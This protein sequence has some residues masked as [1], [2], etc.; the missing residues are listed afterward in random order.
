MARPISISV[1]AEKTQHK[2]HEKD[3]DGKGALW[4]VE[5]KTPNHPNLSGHIRL[6]GKYYFLNGWMNDEPSSDTSIDS[7]TIPF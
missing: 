7:D 4:K 2:M 5:P 1:G 3:A 6:N